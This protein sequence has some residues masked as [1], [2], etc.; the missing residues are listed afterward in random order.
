MSNNTPPKE[1]WINLDGMTSYSKEKTEG[2][3]KL[4]PIN[5]QW[6]NYDTKYISEHHH[7]EVVAEKDNEIERF[8]LWKDENRWFTFSDGKWNYTFEHPTS[9]GKETYDKKYRKT[10]SE[11]WNMFKNQ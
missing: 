4:N 5:G 7:N 9:I 2:K 10:T 3:T 1:I 8:I 6:Y 11:L